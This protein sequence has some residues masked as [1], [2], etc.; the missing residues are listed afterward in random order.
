MKSKK[1]VLSAFPAA[2]IMA[3][4]LFV[5]GQAPRANF[6]RARTF[7]A[8]HYTIRA[9]FG[10]AAKTVFGD[11]TVSLKPLS[12]GFRTVELDAVG[13]D[14]QSVKLEPSGIDLQY[15]VQPKKVVITLDKSY[16]PEDTIS[17]RL[18]YTTT[19][20][21]KG[22]Y[23]QPAVE[24]RSAQIWTQGEAEEARYWFPCFDFPSDKATTEEILTVQK[25]ET[26]IGNGEFLGKSDNPDNTVTWHYRMPVPHSTYLVSFVIGEYAKVEDK[27]RN[28]PLGFYVYPGREA[29]ARRAFGDT[30]KMMKVYEELTGID[31]P[32]N[33]YDQTVVA[34]FQFGGMENITATTMSDMEIF[35]ADVDFLR[36]AF[37]TDLVSHE[38][39]H[40]WFGDLVT[41]SNWAELWLNE[42]FAT[43]MEAAYREKMVGREDYIRKVMSDASDFLT[44][45]STNRKRHALYNHRAGDV[46]S[47]FE[48]AATTYHKGGAVIHTLRE[49]VGTEAFWRALNIYLNRHKFGN[50][51]STDLKAAMEETSGQDLDWFFEQWVYGAGAPKLDVRQT[52]RAR[53]K[54]L[55]LTVTQTQGDA[56]TP[57]VFKLPLDLRIKTGT[58]ESD[59]K[60]D[61]SKR[62]QTFSFK[63]N[64]KP[65]GVTL[66]PQEKIPLKRVKMRPLVAIR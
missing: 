52:Y 16:G 50:V 28:V 20:P 7:D 36:D 65:L 6:D 61:V 22:V 59:Q 38:L 34:N 18:K 30:G 51:T 19:A 32:Y 66:D 40:S 64:G 31:F 12:A 37:V 53:T 4:A 39:A 15:K 43:Y 63:T 26:V 13:L 60:L 24:G 41:C 25:G 29:T 27:Y 46:D 21:A 33:K 2:V 58:G 44:D 3:A 9:S 23:F 35:F 57:M 54:T 1:L 42:G 49:Q 48:N 62:T 47:L 8:Q 11:T 5:S 17:I 10:R 56:L 45:D 14:V 55:T